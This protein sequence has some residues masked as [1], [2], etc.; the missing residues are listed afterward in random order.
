MVGEYQ[1]EHKLGSG[2][3]GG[4][5]AAVHPVIGKSAAI[6]VLHR[7]LSA[8]GEMMS[9]F[10]AE[11][12]AVNQ[13]QQRNIIDI[14]S[15]G[16][17]DDG[18]QYYVMELLDG[19]PLDAYVRKRGRLPA[20]EAVAVLHGVARALDAA[21]AAGIVHRDLKPENVFLTFDDD[22]GVFP[23]LL[24]FG[25]AK[26]LGTSGMGHKTLT[27]RPIGTPYYMSPEQ[28]RGRDVDH[29]TD[30]YSFGV[31]A[32]EI[33]TGKVPFDAEDVLDIFVMHTS[34]P[35]PHP[36]AVC[37][38]VAA[39]LDA[40]VLAFLEKDPAARPS[41][42]SAGLAGIAAAA[43]I[44]PRAASGP[45]LL[46]AP[47]CTAE[48][49]SRRLVE[50]TQFDLGARVPPSSPT[51]RRRALY[52]VTI[53]A[54]LGLVCVASLAASSRRALPTAAARPVASLP[55][56]SP[57]AAASP[58]ANAAASASTAIAEAP[59]QIELTLDAVP[60]DVEVYEGAVKLGSAAAPLRFERGAGARRLSFRAPGY[61][62]QEMT[63]P[64]SASATVAVRLVKIAPPRRREVEF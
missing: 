6:K 35:P 37:P 43:G 32:Y 46:A 10:V 45:R 28:C 62:S 27:G 1:V 31:L 9:R 51:P 11:A 14:F 34:A 26:L 44:D 12:R 29:R 18:R 24:D 54:G 56:A 19:V 21:H 48:E 5:Y 57:S 55:P 61:A 3:F 15:F 38:S 30:L 2:G 8:S 16:H 63:L 52:A 25:I 40:P 41:S 20:E 64:M 36:S 13:I 53:A 4:V 39:A 58:A 60:H 59:A 33:L 47:A 23:K 22:G 17:L 7:E 50:S 49:A 42:A